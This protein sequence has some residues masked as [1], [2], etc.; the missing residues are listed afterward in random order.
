MSDRFLNIGIENIVNLLINI[1]L[2]LTIKCAVVHVFHFDAISKNVYYYL[3]PK[4]QDKNF[5]FSRIGQFCSQLSNRVI[6]L[7]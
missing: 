4:K 3:R 6:I 5:N 7:T 1:S 2:K